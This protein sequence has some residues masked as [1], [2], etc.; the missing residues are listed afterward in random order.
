[1]SWDA[2]PEALLAAHQAAL[3]Q[4]GH[5]ASNTAA[6]AEAL[7]FD[8]LANLVLLQQ[9]V[10]EHLMPQLQQHMERGCVNPHLLLSAGNQELASTHIACVELPAEASEKFGEVAAA[11]ALGYCSTVWRWFDLHSTEEVE[12][13]WENAMCD[14]LE[15]VAVTLRL[16][17][18]QVA[19]A[20]MKAKPSHSLDTAAATLSAEEDEKA[21]SEGNAFVVGLVDGCPTYRQFEGPVRLTF[22]CN[23]RYLVQRGVLWQ[24]A[25]TP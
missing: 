8:E 4:A 1:M 10:A 18:G 11:V 6:D 21:R 23:L 9:C 22:L 16:K 7:Q 20:F 25:S 2:L 12:V 17:G 5:L 14:S 15:P 19:V 3:S 24:P 13:L